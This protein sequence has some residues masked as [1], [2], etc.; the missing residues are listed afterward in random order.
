MH[1]KIPLSTQLSYTPIYTAQPKFSTSRSACQNDNDRRVDGGEIR[2]K[3]NG[4]QPQ[5]C[6]ALE[7]DNLCGV[8]SKSDDPGPG[9]ATR[10]LNATSANTNSSI[11]KAQCTNTHV[12]CTHRAQMSPHPHPLDP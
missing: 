5:L 12:C 10:D 6:S 8:Q 1:S 2:V 4:Y 3:F 9:H 7:M 11:E